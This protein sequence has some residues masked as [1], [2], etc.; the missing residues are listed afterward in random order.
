MKKLLAIVAAG[1]ALSACATPTVYAPEGY[2]G[3]RGGYAEQRLQEDRWAVAFSGNSLTSRDMVEMYLLYRAAELT[4]QSGYDWFVTD[5]RQTDAE[6]RAYSM[7]DPWYRG[8]Y[9]PYWGPSWRF[10]RGG[11]WTPWDPWYRDMDMRQTTRYEARAE[12]VMGRGAVP[13]G[14]RHGFNAREV[15]QNLAP[16]VTRPQ[17]GG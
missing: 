1:L 13:S 15:M 6:T 10:Y 2:G 17:Q 9:G 12:I 11:Y 7:A 3:Q 14:E 16:R 4:V 5:F 8:A